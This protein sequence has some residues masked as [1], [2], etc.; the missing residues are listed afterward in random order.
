MGEYWV[1]TEEKTKG[2]GQFHTFSGVPTATSGGFTILC[3]RGTQDEFERL[4]SLCFLNKYKNHAP[5]W[6]GIGVVPGGEADPFALSLDARAWAP[7]PELD[8]LFPEW[9]LPGTEAANR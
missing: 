3:G 6:L 1:Q 8:R 2:D 5:T 9:P 4:Q 7:D